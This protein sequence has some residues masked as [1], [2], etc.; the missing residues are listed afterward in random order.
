MISAEAYNPDVALFLL[1]EW[2]R[3]FNVN[4][5]DDD[6]DAHD[7]ANGDTE[8]AVVER[9]LAHG[10]S[11]SQFPCLVTIFCHSLRTWSN[12]TSLSHLNKPDYALYMC[13]IDR[14]ASP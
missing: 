12:W 3:L 1:S 10:A 4:G 11:G 7:D 6:D 14:Y 5:V 8:D 9:Y 2:A 13:Q